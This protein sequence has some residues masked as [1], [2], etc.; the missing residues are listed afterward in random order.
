MPS[1]SQPN[2]KYWL[3]LTVFFLV[4]LTIALLGTPLVLG[5]LSM[6]GLLYVPCSQTA[7][8]PADY[9]YQPQTVTLPARAGGHFKGYFIPGSNGAAIIMPPHYSSGRS[10]RLPEMDILARRGYAIFMFESRRC[11]GMGPLSLGYSEVDEV[12]DALDYLLSRDDVDPHRIGIY[13][14]SS[15]GA[16]AIMAAARLP[17]LKAVVAEGG[18]GDFVDN[19]LGQHNGEGLIAYFLPLFRWSSRQTYRW[20]T[21]VEIDNLSPV[22][23][24]NQI[25]PRPIL[26]VYGSTEVSLPG[27]RRQKEAAGSNASLWVVAGAGHGNYLSVAGAEYEGRI[28]SFFNQALLQ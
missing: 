3:R 5:A 20:V 23:V 16:T 22:S 25:A 19:A 26:L 7:A 9:G 8:T 17:Q 10:V 12:A 24:I 2:P 6:V 1:D 13:G 11:A 4:S 14:F 15:A 21:G 18:Y 27:G 28:V